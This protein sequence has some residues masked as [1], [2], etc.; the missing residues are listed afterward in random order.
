MSN[1]VTEITNFDEHESF[2]ANNDRAVLFFGS[3]VCSHCRAMAPIVEKLSKYYPT[4]KFAHIEVSE[5]KVENVEGVPVFV[6]YKYKTP[7]G[8]V[9]GSDQKMLINMIETELLG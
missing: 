6:G 9:L 2:I 7:V 8:K 5:V 4:V 1:S 3:I